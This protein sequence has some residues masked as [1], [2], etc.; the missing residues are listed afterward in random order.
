MTNVYN[1]GTVSVET[2]S[3]IVTGTDTF[4]QTVGNV[5]EGDLFT[6]DGKIFFE[7]YQIDTDSQLRIKGRLDE[8]PYGGE[9][10]NGVQY[11]IIQSFAKAPIAEV[12]QNV[13]L[14]QQKWHQREEEMTGWFS[15]ENNFYE[16]TNINGQKIPVITPTGINNLVDGTIN[17]NDFGFPEARESQAGDLNNFPHGNFYTLEMAL[18]HQ[19]VEF[20]NGRKLVFTNKNELLFYQQI[21]EL[22]TG[23]ARYRVGTNAESA[24]VWSRFSSNGE[25]V[26]VNWNNV[27]GKSVTATRWPYFTEVK[28][29]IADVLPETATRFP[30][31]EEVEGR[32]SLQQMPEQLY[33][34]ID[35]IKLSVEDIDGRF[36][37]YEAETLPIIAAFNDE[38]ILAKA[39]RAA[40]FIN[41]QAG[42]IQDVVQS[43]EQNIG[44]VESSIS[45]VQQQV[46]SLG[47][48]E[49]VAGLA[50]QQIQT[51]DVQ[52]A[53]LQ[54]AVNDLSAYMDE[55]ETSQSFAL[56]VNQLQIDVSP[57]GS[58]AKDIGELQ[59]VTLSNGNA[60]TAA[61]KRLSQ[62][63][64]D[65]EGNA[66]AIEQLNLSVSG[67]SG[68]LTGVLSRLD[69]VE[70]TAN[71]TATAFSAV[72]AKVQD[73]QKGN[74]ALFTFAQQIEVT[75]DNAKEGADVAN[76]AVNQ[77]TNQVNNSVTGLS[78]TND[79]AQQAKVKSDAN[80]SAL[81]GIRST[82]ESAEGKASSALTLASDVN[83]ELE[84][85]RA[86]AQLAV[87]SNG[88]V[89]LIQLGSTPDVSEIIFKSM[90][91]IYQNSQGKPRLYFDV[92][93]DDYIFN[94]TLRSNASEN[95]G[96]NHM[97]LS[98]PNGFG[99]DNLTYY[100]GPK[101]MS[102]SKP[103]Y[104]KAKKSN[105]T[106]WRD[107][108]GDSY[109][110]GSL[111]AGVLSNSARSTVLTLNPSVEVGPFG[112]N[113]NNKSVVFGVSWSGDSTSDGA[114]NNGSVV[115]SCTVTLQR[116]IGSGGWQTI[117]TREMQGS[118]NHTSIEI[119][120][121]P[122]RCRNI[123]RA[124]ESWTYTDT[125]SSSSN[126]SYRV[127][128][129]SQTRWH[130]QQFIDTQS[131]TL[132]STEE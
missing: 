107:A 119:E 49:Q 37:S 55:A 31:M 10:V 46:D 97:E 61:N 67:L 35:S 104:A 40:S 6:L 81:T 123:E 16:I 84:E 132:I 30:T 105:A 17:I 86:V 20:S 108:A 75:A 94:G 63:E 78:A 25:P 96:T 26:T 68:N 112:T 41:D 23:E 14:L 122:T 109:F 11:S 38:D 59:A 7:I 100:F 89:A 34:D 27:E 39:N 102:G 54:Q 47:I 72:Q 93:E 65:A 33:V 56:A 131:V 57:E 73:S 3:N 126:F 36:E 22:A 53:L 106:Q 98:N 113:G 99:P 83:T 125:N 66:S 15:S 62:V 48:T 118:T 121:Q 12:A 45:D 127:L 110:G 124:G 19:P 32:A 28:G 13:V 42:T 71:G 76:Y 129:S 114:C 18:A 117:Q 103:D 69:S 80:A 92:D 115:P 44:L 130:A 116:K 43:F 91:V 21:V 29:D 111:S 52:A 82:A 64:T 60:I 88:N 90:R 2:N 4:F 50:S 8:L 5:S 79:I 74:D 85:Y 77:L 120:G 95:I 9:P 58:L 51:Y 128:V 101:F 70:V 24:L 1:T 87:D